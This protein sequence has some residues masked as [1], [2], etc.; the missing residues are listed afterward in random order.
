MFVGAGPGEKKQH[1]IG[2]S[3]FEERSSGDYLKMAELSEEYLQMGGGFCLDEY[4]ANKG[5]DKCPS[6]SAADPAHC[7]NVGPVQLVSSPSRALNGFQDKWRTDAYDKSIRNDYPGT[8]P[9]KSLRAM[10]F[11]E[12]KMKEDGVGGGESHRDDGAAILYEEG[13]AFCSNCN[14][15]VW[16]CI[17][18]ASSLHLVSLSCADSHSLVYLG[19]V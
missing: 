5:T 16:Q 4:G 7:S 8:T 19:F 18:K 6:N 14:V 11:F 15:G 1:K 12:K 13:I 10:P 17:A 2:D 9:I 3:L